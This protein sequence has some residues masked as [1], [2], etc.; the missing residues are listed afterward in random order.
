MG[1]RETEGVR[2]RKKEDG[3]G[4]MD[5]KKRGRGSEKRDRVWKILDKDMK[6]SG[7]RG[8]EGSRH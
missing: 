3:N 7:E 4:R 5:G 1:V 8:F 2:R 6:G